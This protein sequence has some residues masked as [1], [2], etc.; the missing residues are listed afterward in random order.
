LTSLIV[1]LQE[2]QV[3]FENYCVPCPMQAHCRYG[4]NNVLQLVIDCNE[5]TR[6]TEEIRL[7]EMKKLQKKSAT[8][9]DP[10]E[11]TVKP[12]QILSGLWEKH[13]KKRKEEFLCM[14]SNRTDTMITSQR[15]TDW[16]A[17]FR[18]V[19]KKIYEEC[20]RIV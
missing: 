19:M 10:S 16:W 17:D 13:I 4:K 2:F 12:T 11:I 1:G 20:S 9:I 14:D 6:A 8:A 7:Q 5:M 15:G 3:S 18:E